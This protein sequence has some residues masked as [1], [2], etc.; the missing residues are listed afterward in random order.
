MK[1]VRG[2]TQAAGTPRAGRQTANGHGPQVWGWPS[3]ERMGELKARPI[4]ERL[5]YQA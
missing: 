5:G 4:S 1:R 3:G 2:S